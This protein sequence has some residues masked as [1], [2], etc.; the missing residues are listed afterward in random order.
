MTK[1]NKTSENQAQCAIQNVTISL[2]TSTE[3]LEA[4]KKVARGYE[5]QYIKF[6]ESSFLS[7][8][9]FIRTYIKEHQRQ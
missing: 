9:D 5:K 8:V 1:K 6:D 4:M 7:G 2:P 3:T